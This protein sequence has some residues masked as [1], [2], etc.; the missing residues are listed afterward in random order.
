MTTTKK[1]FSIK[2]M[3]CASCVTILER[4]LKKVDGV[5][6]AVVNLA[7]E[8]ATVVYD[9][10]KI[11]DN[12]LH[13]AVA[14]VGYQASIAEEIQ[15]ED[16]ERKEKQKDLRDLRNKVS[17]SL[18]L[19]GLILWGSFPVLMQTAPMFL[20]NFW[21]QLLLASPVQ[22][23]AGYG[24]YRATI[25]ALRHRTANMDTLVAL[26][27]SV[28]FGYSAFVTLFPQLVTSIGINPM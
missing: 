21:L 8:K 17:V 26:G 22:F 19:G 23:W 12:Y 9:P 10:A 6:Q 11:T 28:A 14:N 7:T 27:T 5:S 16:Q 1:T 4:S 25:S 2:G 15:T 13:S 20:Q 18:V 24:F 3:H